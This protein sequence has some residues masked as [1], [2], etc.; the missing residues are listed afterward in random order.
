MDIIGYSNNNN[1]LNISL[2]AVYD[3]IEPYMLFAK[4][5]KLIRIHLSCYIASFLK[6]LLSFLM[7]LVRLHI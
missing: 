5:Q 1:M 6:D 4:L 7:L 2:T 3:D